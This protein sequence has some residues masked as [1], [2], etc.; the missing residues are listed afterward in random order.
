MKIGTYSEEKI[1]VS[2]NMY[3][4]SNII[5]EDNEKETYILTFNKNGE[6]TQSSYS[7]GKNSKENHTTIYK[8][9]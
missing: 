5:V 2:I 9:R 1:E 4:P 7:E 8:D 6:V 3:S